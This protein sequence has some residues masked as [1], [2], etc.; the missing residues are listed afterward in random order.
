MGLISVITP[1]HAKSAPFLQE[2]YPSLL[3]QTFADW[4]WVVCPNAGG[5]IPDNI[6]ADPRVRVRPIADDSGAEQG[7]NH[8]G[9]IKF[10]AFSFGRGDILVE[11][12]ADDLLTPN[13]LERI[14]IAFADPNIAMVYS[15]DAEF[16]HETWE[17][18][19]YSEYWGWRSRDFLWQ[20][21]TLKEMIAW[22]PSPHM[23]RRVEWA[24]NHVRA[25]RTTAYNAVGGHDEKLKT[26]DD[27][28]LCCRFYLTYG[29]RGMKHIDECLYLYRVHGENS[30]VTNNAQIQAET[31]R[32]YMKYIRQ[33]ATRWA[34]DNGLHLLD[35]G[36]RF[37]AW[38]GYETVD[39]LDADLIMDLNDTWNVPDHSVGVIHAAHI[40]EHL[41]DPIHT[42]NEAYRVLA[43]GG[44]LFVEV[45]STDGRGAW[46]DPTHISFWNQN[47]F[48]YYVN[49]DFAR[50][51]Q[52][53][54]QG[55]FQLTHSMTYFPSEFEKQHGIPIVLA[56]LVAL[57]SPYS[58]RPVGEVLI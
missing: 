1:V 22:E 20:G 12:D 45:P 4:E 47:S 51:I 23:M 53:E 41:K 14:A 18:N 50:F 52:P 35:L 43:P 33:M 21:H 11:L 15:N 28:D 26:A 48:W 31:Q 13:A 36:G 17:S 46:Q 10:T 55:R 8:I 39:R 32:N 7:H 57:K 24:P 38:E 56:D 37:N 40:F 25:F 42:M 27:H 30:C 29:A 58:D 5:T 2:T 49:R 34:R 54:Y 3:A 44:F 9:R 16:K 19:A 6:A